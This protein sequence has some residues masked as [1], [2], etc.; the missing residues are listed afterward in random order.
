MTG[1]VKIGNR[2]TSMCCELSFPPLSLIVSVLR[3]NSDDYVF[4]FV[5][6]KNKWNDI[7]YL[8]FSTAI[9]LSR[10]EEAILSLQ[11]KL[12]LW[13]IDRRRVDAR[14]IPLIHDNRAFRMYKNTSSNVP[15][16]DN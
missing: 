7:V 3:H 16:F 9:F 5:Q 11:R 10:V 13:S 14:N 6:N 4:R 2:K 12:Y 8:V 1:D 15:S